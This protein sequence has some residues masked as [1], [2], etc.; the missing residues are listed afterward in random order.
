MLIDAVMKRDANGKH[1]ASYW[2]SYNN[3]LNESLMPLSECKITPC[4]KKCDC[5]KYFEGEASDGAGGPASVSP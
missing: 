3:P 1:Y 4:R 5:V 2:L